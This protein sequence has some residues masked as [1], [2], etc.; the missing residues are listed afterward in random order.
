LKL[1][2]GYSSVRSLV[3]CAILVLLGACQD[4]PTSPSAPDDPRFVE[5]IR[6]PGLTADAGDCT[7]TGWTR[8][9][10]GFCE[11]PPAPTADPTDTGSEDPDGSGPAGENGGDPLSGDDDGDGDTLDDGPG[12][13]ALCVAGALGADGWASLGMSALAAFEVYSARKDVRNKHAAWEDYKLDPDWSRG[14]EALHKAAYDDAVSAEGAMWRALTASGVVS[15]F[16]LGKAAVACGPTLG[17][18]VP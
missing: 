13:F 10:H 5:T 14:V 4:S 15:A 2:T 11:P 7:L 17:A 16:A 12:A 8:N 6:L 3:L 1:K 9:E 18:P